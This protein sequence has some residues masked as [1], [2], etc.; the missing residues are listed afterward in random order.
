M[1]ACGF[2]RFAMKLVLYIA[3]TISLM[4]LDPTM[5]SENTYF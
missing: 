2:S 5:L 4:I 1:G 3:N